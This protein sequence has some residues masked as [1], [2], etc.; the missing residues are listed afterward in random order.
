MALL[1]ITLPAG[2]SSYRFVLS[3]IFT[4]CVLPGAPTAQYKNHLS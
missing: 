3:N 1:C 2:R 4:S